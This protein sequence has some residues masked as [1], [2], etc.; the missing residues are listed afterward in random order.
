MLFSL[1]T[2]SS[3]QKTFKVT[4]VNKAHVFTASLPYDDG[5]SYPFELIVKGELNG[6]AFVYLVP[7]LKTNKL[8]RR[9][10]YFTVR[11]SSGSFNRKLIR[12][13]TRSQMQIVYQPITA[14]TGHVE[15]EINYR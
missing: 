11:L 13:F 3:C 5:V 10:E 15:I 1:L 2:V 8:A 12:G 14:N 7:K 6:T 4:E 9:D